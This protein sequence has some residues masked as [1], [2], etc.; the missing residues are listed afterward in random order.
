MTVSRREGEHYIA[1]IR[2]S[3]YQLNET[4]IRL[5]R[6]F[7]EGGIQSGEAQALA[8]EWNLS[9]EE[10]NNWIIDLVRQIDKG[11]DCLRGSDLNLTAPAKVH[12]RVTQLCNLHCLHCIVS[13]SPSKIDELI[14]QEKALEIADQLI[15]AKVFEVTLSGGEPFTCPWTMDVV[16]RLIH[17]GIAVK[18]F[19][20]GTLLRNQ[21]DRLSRLAGRDLVLV[22]SVD[23]VEQDHDSI[24]GEGTFK[25]TVAA[26]QGLTASAVR[27]E[28]ST[29]I[30][31]LNIA[32]L[33][34]MAKS[35]FQLG[36]KVIQFTH[37][38]NGGRASEN[39]AHLQ[40]R[41]DQLI[42]FET[43]LEF[44]FADFN[45]GGQAIRY[46]RTTGEMLVNW[47]TEARQLMEVEECWE[48]CAGRTRVT[49]ESSGRVVGC[50]LVT[51]EP[52]GDLGS[53]DLLTIWRGP[54]REQY[55]SYV[56][57]LNKGRF[58][59]GISHL[60]SFKTTLSPQGT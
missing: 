22:I 27:V 25:R 19:S 15:D 12:W 23:G 45:A 50:P 18:I 59:A 57:N 58:C 35:L 26:I 53:Q 2:N 5:L 6:L 41:L 39:F 21:M 7:D 17:G 60:E 20:N 54:A 10:L 37:L 31:S 46:A 56:S 49:I 28:V 48:C 3:Y 38:V 51:G 16:E 1:H 33:P 34:A 47:D 29:V 42:A 52:L 36:V 9:E 44:D 24:R 14:T 32:R 40:P 13:A 55:I 8:A 11:N 43:Q 30:N 4:A